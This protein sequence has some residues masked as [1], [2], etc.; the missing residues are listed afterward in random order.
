MYVMLHV[1]TNFFKTGY[2]GCDTKIVCKPQ[3]P[4]KLGFKVYILLF[5][6]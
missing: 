1:P 2:T 5:I 4:W 3:K 6:P